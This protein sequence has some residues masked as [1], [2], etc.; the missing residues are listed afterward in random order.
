MDRGWC[1]N[2]PS[3]LP[4]GQLYALS[5]GSPEGLSLGH[6]GQSPVPEHCPLP[7]PPLYPQVSPGASW[8]HLLHKLP[9]PKLSFQRLLPDSPAWNSA[10]KI[11]QPSN[12]VAS[13]SRRTLMCFGGRKKKKQQKCIASCSLSAVGLLSPRT[14]CDIFSCVLI[15][16][17]VFFFPENKMLSCNVCV[18]V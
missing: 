7:F 12:P 18:R 8:D 15:V 2:N 10:I 13:T 14:D 6:P 9:V 1:I 16:C 4:L 17:V 5:S 3:S 11:S